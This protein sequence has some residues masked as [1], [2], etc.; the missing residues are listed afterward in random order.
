MRQVVLGSEDM[1]RSPPGVL[2]NG[3]HC[4]MCSR[5]CAK[6]PLCFFPVLQ[7]IQE[8]P[9][10]QPHLAPRGCVCFCRTV[11]KHILKHL[12]F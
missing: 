9:N 3:D 12:I 4:R 6:S 8:M 11:G 7:R 2:V 1:T 5:D 10:R